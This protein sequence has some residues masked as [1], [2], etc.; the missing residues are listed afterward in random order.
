MNL[1]GLY[2]GPEDEAI[3]R[4][5]GIQVPLHGDP[6]AC[7]RLGLSERLHPTGGPDQ[8]VLEA[9]NRAD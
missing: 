3:V 9:H 8:L 5:S 1:D 7:A 4:Q 2:L 6:K